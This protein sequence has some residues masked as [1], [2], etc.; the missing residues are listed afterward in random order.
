MLAWAWLFVASNIVHAVGARRAFRGLGKLFGGWFVVASAATVIS[1]AVTLY[2]SVGGRSLHPLF[3]GVVA[4]LLFFTSMY[5]FHTGGQRNDRFFNEYAGGPLFSRYSIKSVAGL[6]F[7]AVAFVIEPLFIPVGILI[8]L[9]FL[10]KYDWVGRPHG[11][12]AL[13]VLAALFLLN[14]QSPASSVWAGAVTITVAALITS[15]YSPNSTGWSRGHPKWVWGFDWSDRLR[16]PIEPHPDYDGSVV[17]DFYP[18]DP[19]SDG[20][21][22]EGMDE[23][24]NPTPSGAPSDGNSSSSGSNPSAPPNIGKPSKGGQMG[25]RG[26]SNVPHANQERQYGDGGAHTQSRPSDSPMNGVRTNEGHRM[27]E[28]Q[29]RHSGQQGQSLPNET[30]FDWMEPPDARFENIGGYEDV[31]DQLREE[32]ILPIRDDNPGFERYNIEPAQGVLFHGPPGTGKTLFARALANELNKPFVEL[33]QADLTSEYINEGSQLVDEVFEEAQALGGVVFIDEAEQL[34]SE[35]TGRNQHNEDQK[36]MNT[37]LSELS[38]DDQRFLV[39][40]TTNRKDLMD[41][42]VLR[43]GRVDREIDLGLPDRDARIQILKTKLAE[44][45]HRMSLSDVEEIADQT[46]GWS[47]ADLDSLITNARR[48]AALENARQLQRQ[49]IDLDSVDRSEGNRQ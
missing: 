12:I 24:T 46:A 29:D 38:R 1:T 33:S 11:V 48:D 43:P 25:E 30:R 39:I 31:K 35:R 21:R 22:S 15:Y 14:G 5:W 45:P 18:D 42:A 2:A 9:W 26:A 27:E 23:S 40:L 49:H 7:I 6:T 16:L 19:G 13:G 28:R 17:N 44:I 3:G 8:A 4:T 10:W 47:G 34:L 32:V 41:E 37:F 20:D 36:V